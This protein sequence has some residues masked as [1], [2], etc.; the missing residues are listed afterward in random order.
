[1]LSDKMLAHI[2]YREL[3]SE[4]HLQDWIETAMLYESVFQQ[5]HE[6]CG[7]ASNWNGCTQ[8]FLTSVEEIL[9]AL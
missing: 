3:V 7:P 9:N 1:M 8:D 4:E 2:D 5:I 6:C